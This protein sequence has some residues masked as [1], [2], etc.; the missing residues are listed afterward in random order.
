[1]T[2]RDRAEV[3]QRNSSGER[4]CLENH[5]PSVATPL[6][7]GYKNG[8]REENCGFQL[9]HLK[10]WL[11]KQHNY[12]HKL[13]YKHTQIYINIHSHTQM[14]SHKIGEGL[15]RGLSS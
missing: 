5:R 4:A 6:E 7:R 13:I 3:L 10:Q 14:H 2:R 8:L 11:Y 1:M 12:T 9:S 15:D